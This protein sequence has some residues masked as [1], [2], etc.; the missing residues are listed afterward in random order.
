M[1]NFGVP[2]FDVCFTLRVSFAD[3]DKAKELKCFWCPEEKKWKKKFSNSG[4]YRDRDISDF[5]DNV[6]HFEKRCKQEHILIEDDE[7]LEELEDYMID[8][9]H[10]T[11]KCQ[12]VE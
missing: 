8:K 3:K 4:F 5:Y 1:S 7:G 11:N 2:C 6:K 12:I 9:E 10:I